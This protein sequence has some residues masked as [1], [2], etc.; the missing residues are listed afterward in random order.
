VPPISPCKMTCEDFV[1]LTFDQEL[2][3]FALGIEPGRNEAPAETVEQLGRNIAAY[4]L[5]AGLTQSKAAERARIGIGEWQHYEGGTREPR[6]LR[7]K[8]IAGALSV[9]ADR[10]LTA[11]LWPSCPRKCEPPC[12]RWQRGSEGGSG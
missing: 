11:Y 4:R 2:R 1:I 9:T 12:W 6:A 3:R 8:A 7:I 10:L 5:A